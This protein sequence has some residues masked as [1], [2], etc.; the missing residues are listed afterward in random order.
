MLKLGSIPAAVAKRRRIRTQSEWNVLI[1]APPEAPSVAARCRI[2]SAALFVN[3][4]AQ[5]LYGLTPASIN[6]AIR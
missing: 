3:V 5:M 2:S 4:I 1:W 6:E